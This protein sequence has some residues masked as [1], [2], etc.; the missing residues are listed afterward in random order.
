MET[1][2][3]LGATFVKLVKYKSILIARQ[4]NLLP[5]SPLARFASHF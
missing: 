3:V 4:A 5:Q 2:R 1:K